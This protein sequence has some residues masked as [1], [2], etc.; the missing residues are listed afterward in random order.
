[1][2]IH[3]NRGIQ[4][5]SATALAFWATGITT[6][7]PAVAT[8]PAA[9]AAPMACPHALA[10][11]PAP[12]ALAGVKAISA[13]DAWAVGWTSGALP[14]PIL[15]HWNGNS[16][17]AV[18][19]PALQTPAVLMAVAKFPGGLWAVGASGQTIGGQH[20][21]H[22]ILRVT[23]TTVRAVPTPKP[24]GGKLLAVAAT[25]AKN[26]WATGYNSGAGP[27]ILHWNGTAW[28]RSALPAHAQ[29][30]INGV[31][32][33]SA[34]NAWAIDD[35]SHGNSQIWHWNGSRWSRVAAPVIKGQTYTLGGVAATSARNAWAAGT[36]FVPTTVTV[37]T[38]ILHWNGARWRRT[39]SPNPPAPDGD[40]LVAVS[41][42]SADNAWA[43]GNNTA[44]PSLT[45][46]WNGTSWRAVSAP[47]CA[48]L[49]GVSILPRD[50]GWAVGS[51]GNRKPVILRWNGTSWRS[52]P[53]T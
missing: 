28:A 45:E 29:G 27:L 23:G 31:A 21:L 38:V 44:G 40:A 10:T 13:R 17:S 33:T 36:S 8:A 25:S 14:K 39:P 48:D 32:A 4:F 30:R 24:L 6:A 7:G 50:H 11:T 41:A 37:R 20:R 47:G 51:F 15:A 5:L 26:A 35:R 9:V 2:S 53:L 46:H 18:S 49:A 43:V 52:M 22:L 34:T 1:V 16:W 3:R 12:K 19:S 42:S